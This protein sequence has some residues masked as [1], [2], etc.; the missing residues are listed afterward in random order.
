[1]IEGKP[2]LNVPV[3]KASWIAFVK[4][5]RRHR[6]IWALFLLFL[7]ANTAYLHRVPGLFGDEASEGDNVY[8]LLHAERIVVVGER[9]YIGPLI[10]YVR[11]PFVLLLGYDALALRLVMLAVS[12]ATFWLAA[13]VF[14]RLWGRQA[15]LMAIAMMFFS[16]T[17]LLYQRLGWAITLFPF[18][19]LLLLYFLT[20]QRIFLPY[21]SALAGLAAG[22]GLQ[23]YVVFLPTLVGVVVSCVSLRL[24]LSFRQAQEKLTQSH[25]TPLAVLWFTLSGALRRGAEWWL[26]LLGFWAGFGTQF[27]VI[28]LLPQ[29]Q[30]NPAEVLSLI[31][32]RMAALPAVLPLVLSGSSYA[33]RYTGAEFSGRLVGGVTLILL[34]L[35]GAAAVLLPRRRMVWLVGTG[36]ILQL[37]VLTAMVDRFTLRYLVVFVLGVWMLAGV[38]LDTLTRRWRTPYASVAV[39]LV[40][41]LWTGGTVLRPYLTTGGSTGR[42]S[43]GNRTDTSAHFAATEPLYDCLSGSGT[44]FSDDPHILNSLVYTS[45]GRTDIEVPASK[46]EADWL[47]EF[48]LPGERSRVAKDQICPQLKHFRVVKR[49]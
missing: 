1:V 25:S 21:R 39:A 27:A 10:D 28:Q 2:R 8:G 13:A 23:S 35:A 48:I 36:L 14:R 41:L 46:Y 3:I 19:A 18:F 30:G 22:L 26:A 31:W 6:Y 9:S 5:L 11:A 15:V 45:R 32:E 24:A 40:L 17:Y 4:S 43:L 47:V 7:V 42:F 34:V 33:A 44:V 38:G 49:K 16:P 29:D 37:L 20:D 12:I